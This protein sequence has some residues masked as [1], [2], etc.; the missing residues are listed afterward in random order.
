[1]NIH[2][3]FPAAEMEDNRETDWFQ[4]TNAKAIAYLDKLLEASGVGVYKTQQQNEENVPHPQWNQK[5]R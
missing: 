4:P 2:P 3:C 1:M 5:S